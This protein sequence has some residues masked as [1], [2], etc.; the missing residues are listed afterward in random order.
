[1]NGATEIKVVQQK[2]ETKGMQKD[3]VVAGVVR[4]NLWSFVGLPYN[5]IW[6]ALFWFSICTDVLLDA[7]TPDTTPVMESGVRQE[8]VETGAILATLYGFKRTNLD[9]MTNLGLNYVD[10]EVEATLCRGMNIT[11]YPRGRSTDS[12]TRGCPRWR[13]SRSCCRGWAT[14]AT[15]RTVLRLRSVAP[16]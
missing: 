12:S 10:C 9:E 6:A 11:S 7:T 14:G 3:Y 4:R 13:S 8:L 1:M 15:S 5:F 16:C 2:K